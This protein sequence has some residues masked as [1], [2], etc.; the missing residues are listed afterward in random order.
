MD[1]VYVPPLMLVKNRSTGGAG[2]VS[3][4]Y[5]PKK[6]LP[7][8]WNVVVNRKNKKPSGVAGTLWF[9]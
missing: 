1:S 9:E 8:F 3:F 5:Y 7:K 2:R 4:S 6:L